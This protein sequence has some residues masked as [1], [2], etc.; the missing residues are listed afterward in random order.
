VSKKVAGCLGGIILL[1]LVIRLYFLHLSDIILPD[2]SLYIFMSKNMLQGKA[3]YSGP[4]DLTYRQPWI[5]VM[6]SWV[7]AF[8]KN[9]VLSCRLLSLLI[10][11]LT[12]I[13]FHL[14]ARFFASDREV[15]WSDLIYALSSFSILSSIWALPHAVYNLISILL[16]MCVAMLYRSGRMI[17]A[18]S[19]GVAAALAYMTRVEGLIFALIVAFCGV[20]FNRPRGEPKRKGFKIYVLLAFTAAFL[21]FV[22]PFWLHL[23]SQTGLWRLSWTQ[24]K[25]LAEFIAQLWRPVSELNDQTLV[26]QGK[27]IF[28]QH[29][30]EGASVYL[31][32]L[33][34]IYSAYLPRLLPVVVWIF[35][36]FGAIKVALRN[37]EDRRMIRLLIPFI[38]FPFMFYPLIHVEDRYLFPALIFVIIFSG[39]GINWLYNK[40][41]LLGFANEKVLLLGFGFALILLFVPDWY[42]MAAV[43]REEPAEQKKMGEWIRTHESNPRVILG[44]DKRVCFYAGEACKK[45]VRMTKTAT[46][47]QFAESLRR[48]GI[49]LV[50]AD[51]RY[52]SKYHPTYRFLI[53]PTSVEGVEAIAQFTQNGEKIILYRVRNGL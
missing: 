47:A 20:A 30:R 40:I 27:E 4:F 28:F 1:T 9:P 23:K 14:C 21:I 35:V 49:D 12:L 53:D 5:S 51:S 42:T 10:G 29:L 33:A 24:G 3:I 38:A 43:F 26:L 8:G 17:W 34:S 46:A 11:T 48:D 6:F 18:V 7:L 19:A 15:L 25:G 45:M 13:P 52:I 32:N 22:F 16:F 41:L 2:E 44:T 39:V 50:V 36:A 31:K 37:Q